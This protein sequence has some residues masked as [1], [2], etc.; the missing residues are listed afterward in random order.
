MKRTIKLSESDLS[1]L[2][3]ESAKQI[4][5]ESYLYTKNINT[6]DLRVI[7]GNWTEDGYLEWEAR[8]DNGWYT[9]RGTYN[10]I[11]VELDEIIEGHSGH[12]HQHGI[13]DDALEWFNQNLSDKIKSW[14]DNNNG[15][16]AESKM[17]RTVK[18]TE[19]DLHRII[20]QAI[21]EI[22]DTKRGQRMLGRL[23]KRKAD[24]ED[25]DGLNK[26][27]NHA[28]RS[29]V[30]ALG[31]EQ[32]PFDPFYRSKEEAEMGD[33]FMKGFNEAKLRKIVRESML[34]FV[35]ETRLDY[36]DDNFSG[37]WT[38]H[39]DDTIPYE[40]KLFA[41]DVDDRGTI[42]K[43]GELD[44]DELQMCEREAEQYSGGHSSVES[45]ETEEEYLNAID[46]YVAQGYVVKN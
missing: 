9:F 46:D 38:R 20:E 22:G 37:R 25:W 18:L 13:D 15:I 2:I 14:L 10:G 33:E 23:G 45:Y 26:V 16:Q 44:I 43:Y 41:F 7:G 39:P 27:L 12:G 31:I 3:K 17:K 40:G 36:D 29:R 1:R 35:N 30:D 28:V 11:D 42:W 34:K 24:K 21:N 32:G 8:V 5:G 6:D 19:S 4:L